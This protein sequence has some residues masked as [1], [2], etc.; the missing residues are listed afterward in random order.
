MKHTFVYMRSNRSKSDVLVIDDDVRRSK[1]KV[2]VIP[3]NLLVLPP[4]GVGDGEVSLRR[5]A[6]GYNLCCFAKSLL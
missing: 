3:P 6:S 1:S 2:V 5:Q 4:S